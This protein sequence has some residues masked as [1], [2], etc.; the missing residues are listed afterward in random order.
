[1]SNIIKSVNVN[2]IKKTTDSIYVPV[3]IDIKSAAAKDAR[4][5]KIVVLPQKFSTN[6]STTSNFPKNVNMEMPVFVND[7]KIDPEEMGT[8]STPY[9]Y[10]NIFSKSIASNLLQTD[11]SKL[12]IYP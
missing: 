7:N 10:K 5:I 6:Q 9:I 1:M 2:S 11:F 3:R 12:E 8:N 4:Y